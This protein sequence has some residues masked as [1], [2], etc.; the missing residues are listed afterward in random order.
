MHITHPSI[1]HSRGGVEVN[2]ADKPRTTHKKRITI[3]DGMR[4]IGSLMVFNYHF[5]FVYTTKT[6]NGWGLSWSTEDDNKSWFQLPILHLATSRMG[7]AMFF[8]LSGYIMTFN[9]VRHLR[10]RSFES[11]FRA[12]V[13]SALR[14]GPRLYVPPFAW[15]FC[16]MVMVRLG[17]YDFSE[18]LHAHG[19]TFL[20]D[21]EQA[22]IRLATFAEQFWDLWDGCS[23]LLRWWDQ[24]PVL[25]LYNPHL[26]TVLVEFQ[27][28][29]LA[30]VVLTTFAY[31][32]AKWR[33]ILEACLASWMFSQG[34]WE[35]TMYI[36]GLFLAEV[37]TIQ[38]V[39]GMRCADSD[40]PSNI[41]HDIE[42][43][44]HRTQSHCHKSPLRRVVSGAPFLSLVAIASLWICS[45]PNRNARMTPFY[46][47][48]A[49]MTPASFE[50]DCYFWQSIGT[51]LLIPTIVR[52]KLLHQF[53]DSRL[54]QY[55]GAMSF[56]LYVVHGPIL[57]M[58]GHPITA[59][60][61]HITG[62]DTGIGHGLPLLVSWGI[63]FSVSLLAAEILYAVVVEPN[64]RLSAALERRMLVNDV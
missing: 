61:W 12:M 2:H 41:T 18:N 35:M 19:P 30:F 25:P 3:F 15:M 8:L 16:V 10:A 57:H 23:R 64:G 51:V 52:L 9:V 29:M 31:I 26:W 38:D 28:T 54:L 1:P 47:S 4:G 53:F 46:S 55:F 21:N 60:L 42:T 33:L 17:A 49:S 11:A 59:S 50:H 22:P 36:A 56:P 37:D 34:R 58:I 13:S 48:L 7:L 32:E 39:W 27:G 24:E 44:L 45:Y 40:E 63:C 5:F 62:K 14:R 20:G 6:E 43:N